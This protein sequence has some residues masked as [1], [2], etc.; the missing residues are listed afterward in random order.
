MLGRTNRKLAEPVSFFQLMADLSE[1]KCLIFPHFISSS[2][3]P[4]GNLDD[5]DIFHH[6]ISIPCEVKTKYKFTAM[7]PTFFHFVMSEDNHLAYDHERSAS[8]K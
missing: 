7:W 2:S 6:R 5:N 8:N 4:R 1:G 3:V